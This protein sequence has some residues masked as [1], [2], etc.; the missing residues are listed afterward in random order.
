MK[1]INKISVIKDGEKHTIDFGIADTKKEKEDV[2]RLR[3]KIYVEKKRRN[4]PTICS[5]THHQLH[6]PTVVTGCI[7]HTDRTGAP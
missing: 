7:R 5:Q 4:L 6:Q 2:F 3:Y 1:I